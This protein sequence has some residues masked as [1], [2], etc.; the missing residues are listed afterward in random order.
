MLLI[1]FTSVPVNVFLCI[2]PLTAGKTQHIIIPQDFHYG[3]E[4]MYISVKTD[5]KL[6]E[7]VG[8][9]PDFI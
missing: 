1:P 6:Y 8:I 7:V 5:E 3:L 4:K 2:R 9:G